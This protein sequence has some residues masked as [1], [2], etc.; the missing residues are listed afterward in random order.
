MDEILRHLAEVDLP[1]QPTA[2]KAT[3]P[4]SIDKVISVYRFAFP[5]SIVYM[6]GI[7]SLPEDCPHE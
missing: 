1:E 7:L 6:L 5:C 3:A 4:K 2:E